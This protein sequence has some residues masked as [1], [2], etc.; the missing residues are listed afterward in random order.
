M[1]F[2]DDQA[3]VTGRASARILGPW[4]E[5]SLRTAALEQ[6]RHHA[7]PRLGVFQSPPEETTTAVEAALAI[8]YRH[9]DTAA[10]G[11]DRGTE[12][13]SGSFPV[14]ARRTRRGDFTAT[15]SPR[16]A[17]HGWGIR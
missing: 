5:A 15:G 9:I 4:G 8:G 3:R 6:R 12:I 13:A 2:V 7:G 14:A 17:G 16:V 11:N 10:Y 1:R